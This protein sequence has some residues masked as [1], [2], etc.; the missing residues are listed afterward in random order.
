MLTPKNNFSCEASIPPVPTLRLHPAPIGGLREAGGEAG[1]EAGRE[2]VGEAE[3]E[4]GGEAEREAGRE[5]GGE[6]GAGME[7]GRLSSV[8]H[9]S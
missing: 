4:A 6:A 8:R 5:A 9:I 2:A 3:G 7:A 1:R